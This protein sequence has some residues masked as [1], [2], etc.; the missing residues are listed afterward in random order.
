MPENE[1]FYIKKEIFNFSCLFTQKHKVFFNKST[2][3][4]LLE[5]NY[6]LFNKMLHLNT[7]EEHIELK[8]V[9]NTSSYPSKCTHTRLPETQIRVAKGNQIKNKM[10]PVIGTWN[11]DGTKHGVSR[12]RTQKDSM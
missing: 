2:Q 5:H 12:I 6:N 4:F 9:K 3:Q 7:W 8:T 11:L 10:K 1:K